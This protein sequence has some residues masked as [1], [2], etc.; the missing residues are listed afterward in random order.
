MKYHDMP[1]TTNSFGTFC[2]TS[3]SNVTITNSHFHRGPHHCPS[4]PPSPFPS[5]STSH[6]THL[7]LPLRPDQAT[8][9]PL[10]TTYLTSSLDP[11]GC[12]QEWVLKLRRGGVCHVM[13]VSSGVYM[14]L[15][16]EVAKAGKN[17]ELAAAH[18][19]THDSFEGSWLCK[20]EACRL[21]E[22][23]QGLAY[24]GVDTTRGNIY[25]QVL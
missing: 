19:P 14:E 21:A 6:T 22:Y 17:S 25:W 8:S 4:F 16:L 2:R 24:R 20:A 9:F 13:H 10:S 1:V 23:L 5:S 11:I 15:G 3:S 18:L 12:C 7:L